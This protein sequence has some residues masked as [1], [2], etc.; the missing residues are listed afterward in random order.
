[1]G[2]RENKN[3]KTANLR[4]PRKFKPAKIRART[5]EG[6]CGQASIEGACGQASIEGA[7]GQASRGCMCGQ[8][9][10]GCM[11]TSK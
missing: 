7:C 4:N 11:W 6:T 2:T 3:A 5:V 8:A 10:R 1:M 9:S